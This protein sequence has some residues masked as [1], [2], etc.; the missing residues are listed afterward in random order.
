M[1]YHE[2]NQSKIM[3]IIIK[4]PFIFAGVFIGLLIARIF[5][6]PYNLSHTSMEP[7]LLKNDKVIILK[8]VKPRIGDIILIESPIEPD[9][10]LL[11]RIVAG[12]NDLV[13]IRNKVIYVNNKKMKWKWKTKSIDKQNYPMT[14]TF[15]D[16]MPSNKLKRNEFFILGDNLD[17][18]FD[19]RHFGK[20]KEESII[21]KVIYKF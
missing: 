11:K 14:F 21:G 8:H 3:R 2:E 19:S 9:K 5:F 1:Y 12:A 20:I 16:N 4:I 7:N 15:R 10:V 18:G 17:N 6:T 13:E